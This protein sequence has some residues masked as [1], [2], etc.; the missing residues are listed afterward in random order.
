M[1][2]RFIPWLLALIAALMYLPGLGDASLFDWDEINFAEISREM[3]ITGN[4][5]T[6]QIGFEAFTE[7]PPLFCWLQ[8]TSFELFGV[9]EFAARFPNALCGIL[10]AP[11]L[12]HLGKRMRSPRFGLLWSLLYMGSL[13]P[14]FYFQTG[15]IDPVFN[16]LTFLGIWFLMNAIE[17]KENRT[18]PW[19]NI[20]IAGLFTGLAILTKGPTA[21]LVAGLLWLTWFIIKRFTWYLNLWHWLGYLLISVGVA[22]LWFGAN[23][24]QN[25]PDFL[26]QFTIRQWDLLT[27]PDAGHG[28]FLL[29]HFPV[30]FLGCFPA[31]ILFLQAIRRN[32]PQPMRIAHVMFW[33]VLILFTLVKTKIMHYSSLTYYPLT[34]LAAWAWDESDKTQPVSG[35]V[36]WITAFLGG[37]LVIGSFALN[38]AIRHLNALIPYTEKGSFA[39]ENLQA[40]VHVPG[41]SWSIPIIFGVALCWIIWKDYRRPN[42]YWFG[43]TAA[44]LFW[45]HTS[46]FAFIEPVGGI[47]QDAHVRFAKAV[48]GMDAYLTCYGFKSYVP[49]YYGELKPG[50]KK[51]SHDAEWLKYGE[52]DKPVFIVAKTNTR[53]DLESKLKDARLLFSENGFYFYI[54]STQYPVLSP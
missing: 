49:F 40:Q 27:T 5:L 6:P 2:T 53:L 16:L 23:A 7:K 50:L 51:E 14:G 11:L 54:R 26:I 44:T 42:R 15:L 19:K 33:V 38:W 46:L 36:R 35:W 34:F 47:S 32:K 28:G 52:T 17:E 39:A 20:G 3:T 12:F 48:S 31:S 37:I 24:W 45:L 18:S 13:L 30:V 21:L 1:K 8:A 22:G 41:W 29:Y 4:W 25:G 43:L 10:L 9:N